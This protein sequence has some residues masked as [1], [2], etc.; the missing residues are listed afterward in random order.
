[1]HGRDGAADA[2]GEEM[3]FDFHAKASVARICNG[4]TAE[5]LAWEEAR[6][7]RIRGEFFWTHCARPPGQKKST[8][9][10]MV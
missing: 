4:R 2:D 1:M 6:A 10:S 5:G 9:A 3:P 7:I 8:A